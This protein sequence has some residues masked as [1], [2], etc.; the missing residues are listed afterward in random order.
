MT[1]GTD[2]DFHGILKVMSFFLNY[3]S[4]LDLVV[5]SI[6]YMT[7]TQRHGVLVRVGA[8]R[9]EKVDELT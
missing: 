3:Y 5:Y 1:N 7:I 8:D 2:S 6:V 4:G 9:K